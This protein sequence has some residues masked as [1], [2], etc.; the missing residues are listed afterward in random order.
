MSAALA[1]VGDDTLCVILTADGEQLVRP[2]GTELSRVAVE[3]AYP[4]REVVSYRQKRSFEGDYW[5]ATL[6]RLIHHESGLEKQF[7]V[8]A[9]FRLNVVAYSWQPLNFLWPRGTPGRRQHI[10]DFFCRL[11]N[12]DGLVV[13]VK[14]AGHLAGAADQ[15]ALTREA[16]NLIGWQYEVFSGWE[17]QRAFNM[18]HLCTYRRTRFAPSPPVRAIAL[19]AFSGGTSFELGMHRLMR[20]AQLAEHDARM[21][22][23]NL[24]WHQLLTFNLE[25]PLRNST[26]ITSEQS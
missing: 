18:E 6:R 1:S 7:A 19:Q 24:M 26:I 12:G 10:P 8:E 3:H 23:Y 15:F 25:Q 17:P 21:H 13:D 2:I 16:C 14:S 5:S 9:D 20:E 11:S 22:L 4:V